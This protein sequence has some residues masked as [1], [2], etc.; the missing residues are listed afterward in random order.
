MMRNV[1]GGIRPGRRRRV[2]SDRNLSEFSLLV[3]RYYFGVSPS[4]KALDFDSSIPRF[5]SW[6]PSHMPLVAVT[7]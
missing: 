7:E 2:T 3:T 4:G 5:E 1:H 6:H